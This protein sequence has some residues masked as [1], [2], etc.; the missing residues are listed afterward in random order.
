MTS[1]K[2]SQI[3]FIKNTF[4]DKI[5]IR[6]FLAKRKLFFLKLHKENQKNWDVN[7]NK[8]GINL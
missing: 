5:D 4:Y 7:S 1:Q 2:S 6:L 3:H 8:L